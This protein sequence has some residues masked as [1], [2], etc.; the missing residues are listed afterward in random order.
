MDFSSLFPSLPSI[1][2]PLPGGFP[3]FGV[4]PAA[5]V[6]STTSQPGFNFGNILG[7]IFTP[8]QPTGQTG[9]VQ[10]IQQPTNYTPI[11]L[12][13]AVLLAIILLRK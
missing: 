9:P 6:Q 12:G 13:G 4:T 1:P 10:V 3:T 7:A 2:G 11:L 8:Q 5:P